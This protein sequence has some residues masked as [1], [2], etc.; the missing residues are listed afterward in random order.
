M[1]NPIK[2]RIDEATGDAPALPLIALFLLNLV[3]EIDQVAFGIVAPEIRDTFDVS[4]TSVTT[5]A[6]IAG[7]L[8]IM[9]AVPVGFLA[10][11]GRR[12]RLVTVAAVA[13]GSMTILTG[14]SGFIG[15]LGLL[16][17]A[18]F[19]AGLGRVMNEP[20]HASLLADYY[21]PARHG[22]V[23]SLH[24]MANPIG[25][26][27][28]LGCGLLADA[29]GWRLAFMLFAVPT[30]IAITL[31]ARL[32]EPERGASIDQ[33]LALRAASRA[34]K[35]PFREA[36]R[37]LKG[38]RT[39]KRTWL[40]AF[41]LGGGLVPIAVFFNFFFEDVYNLDSATS[42]GAVL[43]VWGLGSVAGLAI[44]SRL[45]T[46]AIMDADLPRL[47]V[48]GG[49]TLLTV[50]ASLLL[51]ATGP[52]IGVS[53]AAVFL[54]GLTGAGFNSYALPLGAAVA[55]PRLRS[56]AFGWFVTWVGIGAIVVTPIVSG[57]GEERGYRLGVGLLS[58]LFV[59][60]GLT[61]ASARKFVRRD[62]DQAFASL[63]AE[64]GVAAAEDAGS[65]ALLS[66]R[67]VEVAYDQV[68]VLFGVD[69]EVRPG[70]CVALLGTNGAGKSTLLKAVSGVVDPIGGSIFFD[71]RDITHADAVQTA[72]MGI[73]QVPG[74][75]AVFPTLT[76]AEHLRAAAWLHRND[77][78]K[79]A[80]RSEKVLEIFPRLRARYDQMAGNLSGGEQQML[81]IGMA[82]IGE[83]RLLIIDELSLGLAPTVVEQLLDVVRRIQASG[84]AVL[85][86]EQSLN[87]AL[88]IAD[89]AY[90]LEKGEVR[91][92][93]STADL[94]GRDDI[95]RSVFLSHAIAES[96]ADAADISDDVVLR[97]HE[98]RKRFGGITA[99]D[100]VS[101]ELHAGEVLGFIGANGAGK[102]TVFDCLSGFLELDGGRIEL[103]GQ[104][105]TS[106]SPDRRAWLGLGR[107]FQDARLVPSLTVAENVALGLERHLEVRDHAAAVLGLPG[108]VRQEDDVAWTVADLIELLGLGAYRDKFVR[109][110]STGTRRIVDLAMCIAHEPSVLL[111]DEPSSGIAQRETEALGPVIKRIQAE[112]GCAV[113]LIEHDMPLLAAVSDRVVALELG[114]VLVTGTPQEVLSDPRVIASYLGGDPNVINRSGSNGAPPR[115]RKPLVAAR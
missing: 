23:F 12:L 29:V 98:L 96:A 86:V 55:P 115:R 76:V 63:M 1:K 5:L 87:V 14:L 42:R 25:N 27:S 90:F 65:S 69:L 61:Y 26:L 108:L 56:Q 3:D 51:M 6:A 4:E 30:L 85:L 49:A 38:I 45:S 10:D 52:W 84:V 79:V 24:R 73:I 48:L 2:R 100:D 44:G 7:A 109:E 66:C 58:L 37:R 60:A 36:Y 20:V 57:I 47:A 21:E 94:M 50:G 17:I 106:L 71:G 112:V 53:V 78:A 28:V 77:K 102:T 74:G 40:A 9:L 107:S 64:A 70:E 18:R 34:D 81:A 68:Q 101:F 13:W 59:A 16:F 88:T 82:L 43:T 104:D 22:R 83:P 93:G 80:E 32:H 35:V 114:A 41:F 33:A 89:R 75:K 97:A 99:V 110:L 19:G 103:N 54:V 31:V 8:V 105:I 92:E 39:L 11:R 91:F 113:L 15:A 95:V 62:A 111:L 46:K 67:G 72:S